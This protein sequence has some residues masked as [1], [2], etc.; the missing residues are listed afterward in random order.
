M[1]LNNVTKLNSMKLANKMRAHPALL[2]QK[3]NTLVKKFLRATRYKDGVV[4]TQTALAT[5]KALVKTYP[6]LEKENLV[7]CAT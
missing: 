4:N 2:G 1:N 7:L 6:L 5:I 3:L